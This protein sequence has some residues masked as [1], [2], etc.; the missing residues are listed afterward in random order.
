M[1]WRKVCSKNGFTLPCN[2]THNIVAFKRA[3]VVAAAQQFS[4][5]ESYRALLSPEAR[6]ALAKS[7]ATQKRQV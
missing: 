5:D 7:E 1:K 3:E 2:Q 6:E 4:Y